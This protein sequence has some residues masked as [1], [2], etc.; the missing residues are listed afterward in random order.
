MDKELKD[1]ATYMK[2]IKAQNKKIEAE[3]DILELLCELE[4]K[5]VARGI[6]HM[7]SSDLNCLISQ[8]WYEKLLSHINALDKNLM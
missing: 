8:N 3:L 5:D 4:K 7:V 6:I 1:I 2:I